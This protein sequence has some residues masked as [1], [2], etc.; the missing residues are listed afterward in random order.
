MESSLTSL[1]SE[2]KI[3][4]DTKTPTMDYILKMMEQMLILLE[5]ISKKE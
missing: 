2:L 1:K 5:T 3:E 4:E